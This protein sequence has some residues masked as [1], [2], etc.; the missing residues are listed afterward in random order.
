[1]LFISDYKGTIKQWEGKNIHFNG[2]SAGADK[3]N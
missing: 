1:V 2:D 3:I